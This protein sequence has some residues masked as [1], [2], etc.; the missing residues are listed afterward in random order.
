MNRHKDNTLWHSDEEYDID[1]LIHPGVL[2]DEQITVYKDDK[3]IPFRRITYYQAQQDRTNIFLANNHELVPDKI[4]EIYK[5]RWQIE[6]MFKQIKQNFP[7]K[8]FL[9]DSRKAI[10]IQNCVN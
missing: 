5:N 7:L 3:K 6:S 4:A 1:D 10:E 8:Y 2:K 9:G